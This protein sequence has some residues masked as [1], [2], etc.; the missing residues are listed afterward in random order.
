LHRSQRTKSRELPR[1]ERGNL[2]LEAAIPLG[3]TE[4]GCVKPPLGRS[5]WRALTLLKP[6]RAVITELLV[7]SSQIVDRRCLSLVKP[8]RGRSITDTAETL[9]KSIADIIA[10]NT[11][12]LVAA[13]G[14]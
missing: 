4:G 6:A 10:G 3:L 2:G 7:A 14:A 11:A 13:P 1:Q 8:E 9:A 12:A 5:S